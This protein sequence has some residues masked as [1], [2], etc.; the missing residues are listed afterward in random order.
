MAALIDT[1]I[2]IYHFDSRYP[3][4]Q[5]TVA[6]L[7]RAGARDGSLRIPHQTL[8]EFVAVLSRIKVAGRS[9]LSWPETLREAE[10]LMVAFPI[11]YPNAA[12]FRTALRG[13]AAYQLSWFDAHIWAY[14]EHFG[15]EELLSE[16]F[17]HGRIYGSVQVVNPFLA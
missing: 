5:K 10:E 12:M 8:M 6:E 7:L 2:L 11:L 9:L 15:I 13:V 17:E 4:K 14:A 3:S 16:D 1:N